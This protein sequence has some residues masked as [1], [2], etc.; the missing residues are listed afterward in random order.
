MHLKLKK[1]LI[2]YHKK[3]NKQWSRDSAPYINTFQNKN[4]LYK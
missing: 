4:L 3:K 2:L 1:T